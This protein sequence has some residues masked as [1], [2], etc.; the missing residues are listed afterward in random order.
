MCFYHHKHYGRVGIKKEID[1]YLQ[2]KMF[3]KS[4]KKP[5]FLHLYGFKCMVHVFVIII[6]LKG[7][8]LMILTTFTCERKKIKTI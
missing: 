8:N 5:N 6:S 3:I 2:T 4:C 7:L 1:G